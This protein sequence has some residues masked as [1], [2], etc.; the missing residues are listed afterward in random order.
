MTYCY[1]NF[2]KDAMMEKLS[3]WRKCKYPQ[4]KSSPVGNLIT[5]ESFE[6]LHGSYRNKYSDT[7]YI[8]GE[9]FFF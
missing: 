2:S 5:I 9:L 8:R 4:E 6:G 7:V 1:V 3:N